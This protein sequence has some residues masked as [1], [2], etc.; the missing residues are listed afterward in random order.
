MTPE[1]IANEHSKQSLLE[2]GN[3]LVDQPNP[4]DYG[5]ELFESQNG[6]I[7]SIRQ[8]YQQIQYYRDM[9]AWYHS[10]LQPYLDVEEAQ[11]KE[12]EMKDRIQ[13]LVDI[14]I[15]R[16]SSFLKE[17]DKPIRHPKYTRWWNGA[18]FSIIESVTNGDVCVS[19]KSY[20]GGGETECDKITL[21]KEWFEIDNPIPVVCKWLIKETERFVEQQKEYARQDAIRRIDALSKELVRL[22][23]T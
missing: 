2:S 22:G 6:W 5:G 4:K 15:P 7:W 17:E 19:V 23:Q 21:L 14:C 20:V 8:Q 13:W 10:Q 12:Q 16:H 18:K 3:L 1:E 9:A 11:R